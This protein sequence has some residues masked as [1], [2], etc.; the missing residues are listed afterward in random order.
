MILLA[1]L[2]VFLIFEAATLFHHYRSLDYVLC[3]TTGSK[4]LTIRIR[5]AVMYRNKGHKL[6]F[7]AVCGALFL[8][9]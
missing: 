1:D 3:P 9:Y 5:Y 2:L 8:D 7:K 6:G 4:I